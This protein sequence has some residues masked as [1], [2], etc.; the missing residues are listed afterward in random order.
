MVAVL[1]ELKRR[2]CPGEK[3]SKKKKKKKIK[4]KKNVTEGTNKKSPLTG[5]YTPNQKF[6]CFVLNLKVI[7]T[8]LKNEKK[9]R[10]LLQTVQETQKKSILELLITK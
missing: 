3:E 5:Y 1:L 6:A 8:C 10:I 9:K 7:K 2:E 4:P